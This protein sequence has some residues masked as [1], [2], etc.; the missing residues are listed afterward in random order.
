MYLWHEG[1]TKRKPV[2]NANKEK[3]A[4]V[5]TLWQL[6]LPRQPPTVT[7]RIWATW[8]GDREVCGISDGGRLHDKGMNLKL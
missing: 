8:N 6:S 5:Y 1:S 4:S 3:I 2:N 7:R